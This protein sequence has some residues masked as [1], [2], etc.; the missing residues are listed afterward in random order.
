MTPDTWG[1]PGPTFLV[2]Y[3]GLVVPVVAFGLVERSIG[4]VDA[5]YV[6]SAVVGVAARASGLAV[7][8]TAGVGSPA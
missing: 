2:L 1:I 5:G 7:R 8:R 6:F 3:I 4:L